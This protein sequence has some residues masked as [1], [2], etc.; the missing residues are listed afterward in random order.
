MHAYADELV[1][2]LVADLTPQ[3]V[4]VYL[5]LCDDKSPKYNAPALLHRPQESNAVDMTC[6]FMK[7][8]SNIEIEVM[9][10]SLLRVFIN[11]SLL[12][13]NFGTDPIFN[14]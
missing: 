5:K 2:M 7:H 9:M 1:E 6:K 13:M 8:L 10:N 4:C 3:E 12:T 14:F 11:I